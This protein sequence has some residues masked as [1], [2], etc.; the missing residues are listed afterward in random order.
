MLFENIKV[1]VGYL[2]VLVASH[3]VLVYR[4]C[5]EFA[6]RFMQQRLKNPQMVM[7][8]QLTE[9]HTFFE[10]FT[11]YLVATTSEEFRTLGM[12]GSCAGSRAA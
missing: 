2:L 1:E 3:R 9:I 8:S 6:A 4:R 12:G 10:K 5:R 11:N 7:A